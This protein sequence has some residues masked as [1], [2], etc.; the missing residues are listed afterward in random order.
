MN[1]SNTVSQTL[2]T[3]TTGQ[4]VRIVF[5]ED[6]SFKK[7]EK[8]SMLINHSFKT[9]GL[10]SNFNTLVSTE[11]IVDHV[12]YDHEL[13]CEK[14]VRVI[15]LRQPHLPKDIHSYNYVLTTDGYLRDSRF[16]GLVG[17]VVTSVEIISEEEESEE[18][19]EENVCEYCDEFLCDECF[20]ARAEKRNKN[21]VYTW[22][23]NTDGMMLLTN[24]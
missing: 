7:N 21:R 13:F 10:V 22:S 24:N 11:F 9:H 1:H 5:G 16:F 18:E 6:S 2:F 3:L 8:L 14:N 23:L 4:Y 19:E 17:K 15:S 12:K 20:D